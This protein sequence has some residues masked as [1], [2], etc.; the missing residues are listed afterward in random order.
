MRKPVNKNRKLQKYWFGLKLSRVIT[1]SLALTI[2]LLG[3]FLFDW[4]SAVNNICRNLGLTFKSLHISGVSSEQQVQE[5][6]LALNLNKNAPIFSI[7]LE[8]KRIALEKRL[9]WVKNVSIRRQLPTAIFVR[10]EERIP[11]AR[12]QYNYKC[13]LIDS[14]G[15]VLS[16]DEKVCNEYYNLPLV[17]G[18]GAGKAA[19]KLLLELKKYP[20]VSKEITSIVRVG[21]RRWDIYFSKKIKVMLPESHDNVAL[22]KLFELQKTISILNYDIDSIDMRIAGKYSIRGRQ[23]SILLDK[24]KQPIA[25]EI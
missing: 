25:K 19:N 21:K 14:E 9:L 23:A 12:W 16:S 11:M 20:E 18:D 15:F 2:F 3:I 6:R 22:Q 5:I 17:V 24:N 1:L 8:E 4:G 7:N 10:V 13:Y